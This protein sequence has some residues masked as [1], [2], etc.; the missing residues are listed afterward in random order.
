MYHKKK[1]HKTQS[2]DIKKHQNVPKKNIL[3]PE[4]YNLT[5]RVPR[6]PRETKKKIQNFKIYRN[7]T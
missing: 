6:A 7:L 4:E 1:N 2:S 3:V 5:D